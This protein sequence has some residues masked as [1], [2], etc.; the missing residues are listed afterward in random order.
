M[1]RAIIPAL[2]LVLV[3]VVLGATVF[4]EQVANA[5]ATLLVRETNTDAQGN[6]RVHEQGTANVRSADREVSLT[7]VVFNASGSTCELSD[8]Y[9]VPADANLVVEYISGI[10]SA[11]PS[12]ADGAF[13]EF[14]HDFP[15]GQT[16]DLPLVFAVSPG[17][18]VASESVHYVVP[19]GTPLNF[20]GNV[21]GGSECLM[22]VSLGGYLQPA[23]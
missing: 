17:G 4:R 16:V 11:I 22:K 14:D 10:A 3:S 9:V 20:R 19:A 1:R 15:Q 18:F 8:V 6:I 12:T 2:L 7:R 5:A 13:G 21:E 23:A